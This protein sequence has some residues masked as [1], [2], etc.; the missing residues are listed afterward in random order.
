MPKGARKGKSEEKIKTHINSPET[1]KYYKDNNFGRN[2]SS[3]FYVSKTLY[4]KFLKMFFEEIMNKVIYDNYEFKMPYRIG[5]LFIRKQKP[6]VKIIDGKIRSSYPVDW[7]ET[8]KLW[9]RDKEAKDKKII[10]KNLN[11]HTNGYSFKI[12]YSRQ[13]AN[14]KNKYAW[15]F[16]PTRQH[17]LKLKNASKSGKVDYYEFN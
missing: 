1:Y 4:G 6:S 5:T 11:K 2:R 9:D 3:E 14:Y 13:L 8:L 17:K 7:N 15:W 10:V 12:V 16:V